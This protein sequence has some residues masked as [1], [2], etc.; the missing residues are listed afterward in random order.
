[1]K[2]PLCWIIFVNV[3]K[4]FWGCLLLSIINFKIIFIAEHFC[5]FIW[6]FIFCTFILHLLISYSL[7]YKQL[8]FFT[9]ETVCYTFVFICSA[10]KIKAIFIYSLIS[11][12]SQY[13]H[14]LLY[15]LYFHSGLLWIVKNTLISL[16][17]LLRKLKQN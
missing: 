12:T 17:P 5:C 6:Y 14:L 3:K 1:M 13:L 7:L 10:F 9:F 8:L 11:W 15:F 16:F 4:T 2:R